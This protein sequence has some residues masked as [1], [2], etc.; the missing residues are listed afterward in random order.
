MKHL[1]MSLC[2]TMAMTSAS[3]AEPGPQEFSISTLLSKSTLIV[4]GQ[5]TSISNKSQDDVATFEI[6]KSLKGQVPNRQIQLAKPI[7]LGCAHTLPFENDGVTKL[8]FLKPAPRSGSWVPVNCLSGSLPVEMEGDITILN[9]AYQANS[10]LFTKNST[11]TLIS[12]FESITQDA[13]KLRLLHDLEGVLT[14]QDAQF[15]SSLLDLNEEAYQI[16]AAVQV[17]T[18]KIT[19]LRSK[20]ESLLKTSHSPRVKQH[21]LA[22]LGLLRDTRSLPSILEY[23]NDYN[24]WVRIAAMTSAGSIGGEEIISP[25]LNRYPLEEKTGHRATIIEAFTSL[26]D[27]DVAKSALASIRAME[28]RPV[29]QKIIDRRL[30]KL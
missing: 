7:D 19:A 14:P 8:L 20:I 28:T 17:G 21:C 13:I 24:P 3:F 16:F 2:F 22:G 18:L 1:F 26:P 30:S 11:A 4:T 12:L 25:L 29:L 15:L 9:Q 6:Y 5:I 23:V 10:D 27:K